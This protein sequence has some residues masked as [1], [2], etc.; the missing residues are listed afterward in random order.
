[1]SGVRVFFVR[2]FMSRSLLLRSPTLETSKATLWILPWQLSEV[3][4]RSQNFSVLDPF[5]TSM[6]WHQNLFA[7]AT[8]L[9]T[10]E[11][12]HGGESLVQ[13]FA[14]FPLPRRTRWKQASPWHL[15]GTLH[16]TIASTNSSVKQHRLS[17]MLKAL[18]AEVFVSATASVCQRWLKTWERSPLF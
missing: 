5:R 6:R 11:W 10:A 15:G 8:Q 3:N 12:T 17:R 2:Y 14:L 4:T 13:L 7:V 9:M 1:M 16:A 18:R